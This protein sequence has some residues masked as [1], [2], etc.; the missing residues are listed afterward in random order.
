M[1]VKRD[2]KEISFQVHRVSYLRGKYAD[3]ETL[4]VR[5]VLIITGLIPLIL[6]ACRLERRE[7]FI[8]SID[9]PMRCGIFKSYFFVR[10]VREE[11]YPDLGMVVANAEKLGVSGKDRESLADRARQCTELCEVKK[12]NLRLMQEEIK[13]KLALNEIRGDLSRVQRDVREFED[14]KK[15]WLADHARRYRA[16]LGTLN[17]A[18]R[19]KWNA[20][21]VK[22][23]PLPKEL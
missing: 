12:D 22:F 10:E 1:A 9:Q 4:A 16:A 5:K 7:D 23:L 17:E 3:E 21:S 11:I 2:D 13:R 14:A 18:V 15:F 6:L 20:A 8:F 19:A